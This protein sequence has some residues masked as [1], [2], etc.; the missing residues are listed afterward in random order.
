MILSVKPNYK[1]AA[2]YS[3]QNLV[4]FYPLIRDIATGWSICT[5][6]SRWSIIAHTN[7]ICTD[8]MC[9]CF[10]MSSTRILYQNNTRKRN[11]CWTGRIGP[12]ENQYSWNTNVMIYGRPEVIRM[13]SLLVTVCAAFH[14]TSCSILSASVNAFCLS[15]NRMILVNAYGRTDG[16]AGGF[17]GGN[18]HEKMTW[19]NNSNKNGKR[20]VTGLVSIGS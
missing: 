3:S 5:S 19:I 13:T 15:T 14:S 17:V 11:N 2:F 12:Q 16:R 18:K 1:T 6:W 4:K 20:Y 10:R 9:S 7:H 8:V